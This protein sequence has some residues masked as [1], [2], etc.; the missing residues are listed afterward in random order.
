MVSAQTISLFAATISP[1]EV[2]AAGQL[3]KVCDGVTFML[4]DNTIMH[5]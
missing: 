3:M 2:L 1:L 4:A 5:G